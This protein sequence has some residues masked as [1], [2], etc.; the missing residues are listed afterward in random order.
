MPQIFPTPRLPTGQHRPLLIIG[1]AVA[2]AFTLALSAVPIPGVD[3]ETAFRP[4]ARTLLA[5]RSPYDVEGYFN[6]PWALLPLIPLA[7]LPD[8]L[9]RAA[10]LVV[11]LLG[12]AYVAYRLGAGRLALIAFLISPPVLHG[13]LNANLD[14]L[15]MLGF[16]MPPPIGLFFVAVKPQIGVAVAIF[17]LADSWRE[18]GLREAVRVFAPV[19]VTTLLSFALF[20]F[21]PL[22]FGREVSLWW[23]A[24][25]W[26]LSLPVGLALVV[27]AVRT[28]DLRPAMAASPCLSPY[29]LLHSWVGALAAIIHLPGE[30]LAAVIGL[31]TLVLIQALG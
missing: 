20:G 16:L 5:F 12:Y 23:N 25:L 14:W 29:V 15:A 18:G 19:T 28:R 21:W 7:V 22:R 3:W 13:L 17:W 24:S 1:L 9:G 4:A 30:T 26:P 6:A 11:S 27:A 31:W 10:L 2:L 8:A